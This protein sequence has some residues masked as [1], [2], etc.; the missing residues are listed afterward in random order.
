M[1]L[2]GCSTWALNTRPRTDRFTGPGKAVKALAAH[3]LAF[4]WPFLTVSFV[5]SVRVN[6]WAAMD[7]KSYC[8]L[9]NSYSSGE[10]CAINTMMRL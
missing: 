1:K 8:S 2:T 7:A 6:C 4:V 10:V 3:E 5:V 9:R